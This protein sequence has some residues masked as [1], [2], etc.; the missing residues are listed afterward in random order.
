M[1]SLATNSAWTSSSVQKSADNLN[2]GKLLR[3]P[4]EYAG[5]LDA[6]D[7]FDLTSAI[8]KEF[9]RLQLI[10]ILDDDAKLR[11]LAITGE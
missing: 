5:T 1:A 9:P 7:S 10:D 2:F 3:E 6:Y 11:D 4:L 8:G